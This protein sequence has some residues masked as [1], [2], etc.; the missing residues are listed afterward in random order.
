MYVGIVFLITSFHVHDVFIYI[1]FALS[2]RKASSSAT[3]DGCEG[4]VTRGETDPPTPTLISYVNYWQP[5]SAGDSNDRYMAVHQHL[6]DA[7]LKAIRTYLIYLLCC[8]SMRFQSLHFNLL[9]K[10]LS[11]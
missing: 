3:T 4:P 10:K 11:L 1:P 2:Q 5:Q 9:V 8:D 7:L 6:L